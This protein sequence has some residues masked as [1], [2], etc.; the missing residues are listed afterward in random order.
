MKQFSVRLADWEKDTAALRAVRT[1]V[2]VDEQKVPLDMEWDGLDEHCIHA[3]A[4][5]GKEAIGTGRLT[6]DGHI[7]RM[8]VLADWRGTGVGAELL[9]KLMEAA[10]AR[11]DTHCELNAQVSAIGFYEHF[12]FH[13]EG[14]TFLDAGIVHRR[15]RLD[16]DTQD[17][18]TE[19]LSG[20]ASLAGALLRLARA[21][22]HTFAL[23]A[24]DLAPRLTDS[25]E[26]AAALKDVALSSPH[27]NVRLL[28]QEARSAVQSSHFVLR[29]VTA[30]PSYC[31]LHQLC[32]ED[33]PTDEVYAFN[34]TGGA[35]HQPHI[36]SFTGTLILDSPLSARE[37]Q[38][39]FDPLWKRSEPTPD[40]RRLH[41]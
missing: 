5:A 41:L 10:K 20:H 32:T 13:A 21:A 26:F 29:V 27:S 12:G 38:R 39:R 3:L 31:A 35:F 33:E 6:P 17:L 4:F 1:Q 36:E 40:A 15:M 30:L 18:N 19:S 8:A 22:H 7:G 25:N 2:F 23:Y 24:P 16:Y 14:G 34:D 28:C 37:L 9:L 11:G